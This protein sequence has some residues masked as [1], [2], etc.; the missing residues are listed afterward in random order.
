M[1]IENVVKKF[2]GRKIYLCPKCRKESSIV[3]GSLVC[4][5]GHSYD[6]SKKGYIHLINNYKATK[7]NV[8]LFEARKFVFTNNFYEAVLNKLVDLVYK[9]SKEIVVDI[10]CGEGYYIELLKE[11]FPDKYFYGLDNSKD[12]IELAVKNDKKNAYMLANL[13]NLPFRNNS[14]SCLL[15][16]L[17]PANYDEF[18]RVLE[19]GGYLIK[20]I[21]TENY[22]KEIRTI[23]GA[24]SYSNEDTVNLIEENCKIVERV[25]VSNN[26]KL[27]RKQA[28]NFLKMTP[29]TFSKEI[30]EDDI[31]NLTEITVEL[32]LLVCTR[33]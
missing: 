32:E 28:E 3:G 26:Y 30:S 18:F 11:K 14:V 21:P 19:E 12:A 9:Y 31:S 7:Y 16:V 20:V 15:N 25:K 22:L 10:G 8:E 2:S 4:V 24:K 29:L 5:L 33:L 17:T 13:S 6:F 27:T 1:K 23:T